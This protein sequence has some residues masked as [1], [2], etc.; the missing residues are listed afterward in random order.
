M[1]DELK[2]LNNSTIEFYISLICLFLL[3]S[4][5]FGEPGYS[6]DIL[7]EI[8]EYNFPSHNSEDL[9]SST[10]DLGSSTEENEEIIYSG[11]KIHN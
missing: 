7:N 5:L 1:H 8:Q 6:T 2:F 11:D 10:E 3:Y 4:I 9:G